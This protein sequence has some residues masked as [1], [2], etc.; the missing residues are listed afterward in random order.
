[1]SLKIAGK[2]P[3]GKYL[4]QLK[5]SPNYKNGAFQNLSPTPMKQEGV[6]YWKM[7]KEFFKKHPDTAPVKKL[8]FVKTDLYKLDPSKPVI[9]WFGHSSYL[10]R[11]ENK[12]FL[13]DPVFSG[14]AAPVS[15]MVKAFPGANEYKAED[16]PPI[17]YLIL[18]HDHY[19]HLDFK[20]I[21]KLRNKIDKIYC[22]LG[23]SSHLKHW[24]VD[25]NKI[26][27]MDWWQS[28]QLDDSMKLTAAPARHFSGRGLKRG[29]TLWS[30]FILKTTSC[31]I[32]LGGDSGYDSHFKEIGQRFGPF[33]LAILESGQYNTMWPLI[34]MIPEE[35]VQAAVDLNAKALMPVHWGKFRLGMHP[36][37]EPVKRVLEKAKELNMPVLTPQIG[38]PLII[39]GHFISKK[40]WN[41]LP[42]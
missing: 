32:Y 15:F 10:L 5:R 16:M 35:T 6:T 40:W 1:M 3:A 17:D 12:N 21:R 13:I 11:I 39:D 26:T 29:Q 23:I 31:N 24:G 27:E 28:E 34:H 4:E 18:T 20:T 2:L 30:S 9:V 33:D 36:W 8:P 14:N 7:M 37:N 19:D 42:V 25:G 38:E 41:F 22:S